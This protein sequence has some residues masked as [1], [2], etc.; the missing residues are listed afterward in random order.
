[1]AAIRN[2]RFT[3]TPVIDFTSCI[4]VGRAQPARLPPGPAIPRQAPQRRQGEA[5]PSE[6]S[7]PSLVSSGPKYRAGS[8]LPHRA[9][10]YLAGVARGE[11]RGR[12]VSA[13]SSKELADRAAKNFGGKNGRSRRNCNITFWPATDPIPSHSLT[14]A[15]SWTRAGLRSFGPPSR[16]QLH[17]STR[18]ARSMRRS[19]PTLQ[20]IRRPRPRSDA[21]L[22][23]GL[24]VQ[25]RPRKKP[26]IAEL[27]FF[28]RSC[29]V[30]W[31]QPGSM[32]APR[33][34]GTNFA[35]FGISLSMPA[36]E[37]TRSR[38]PAT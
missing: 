32:V 16:R 14:P 8:R 18:F 3:S 26:R 13:H 33:R 31:P 38:S 6:E 9:R 2:G 28:A 24:A 11:K 22:H 7:R 34:S 17:R 37:T 30:Q 5:Q 20:R 23:S 25:G 35:R 27:T 29:W 19:R 15:F 12:V 1:M 10:I 4:D 36:N 21:S